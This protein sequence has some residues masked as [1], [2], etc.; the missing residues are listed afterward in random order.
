MAYSKIIKAP[1]I[2]I[3]DGPFS[4]PEDIDRS[5]TRMSLLSAGAI[6]SL[7]GCYLARNIWEPALLWGL[8]G[9]SLSVG[10]AAV[11]KMNTALEAKRA[12]RNVSARVSLLHRTSDAGNLRSG[13]EDIK[14]TYWAPHFHVLIAGALPDLQKRMVR[15][16]DRD[17]RQNFRKEARREISRMVLA[18]ERRAEVA[19]VNHPLL[20]QHDHAL[21]KLAV[22]KVLRAKTEER[23]YVTCEKQS[24]WGKLTFEHTDFREIDRELDKRERYL[25]NRSSNIAAERVAA[26]KDID[27]CVSFARARLESSKVS[28]LEMADHEIRPTEGG[29][30]LARQ[31]LLL[32]ALSI[33]ISAWNDFA[34]ASEVYNVLR[35]VNG[36]YAGMSDFEIWM[37]T[38]IMPSRSLAGL[39]SLTKGA[40]FE[41][42]VADNLGGTLHEHFNTP[43]TDILIDGQAFQIKATD[44]EAYIDSVDPSISVISTSEIAEVTG[45]I[46]GGMTVAELDTDITLALG[47]SVIDISDTAL[48][49]AL[50]GFGGLSILAT[51]RG[52]NHAARRHREGVPADEAIEEGV[53][54][55]IVGTAKA[56]VDAAELLYKGAT[57]RPMR[58]IGRQF[59]RA[60]MAGVRLIDPDDNP[61]KKES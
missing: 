60:A 20:G 23:E 1:E 16:R 46:D 15:L 56:T 30:I 51:F 47:G 14:T 45:S 33:P 18:I 48:D 53:G 37:D 22:D 21:F 4:T 27:D 35:A 32:G 54:V 50:A 38:L 9:M 52:I 42:H 12:Y 55:A 31:A 19:R 40:L 24:W 49:A 29:D 58:F 10:V 17:A 28:V 2:R 39:A 41:A 61:S 25:K 43:D 6:S 7:M 36:N 8:V 34:A 59:G 5:C 13:I 57:S 44:S 26:A 11:I 3:T